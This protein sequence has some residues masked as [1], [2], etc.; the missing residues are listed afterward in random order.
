MR[1]FRRSNWYV[2][3]LRSKP[4]QALLQLRELSNTE[5]ARGTATRF[6]PFGYDTLSFNSVVFGIDSGLRNDGFIG[7]IRNFKLFSEYYDDSTVWR[8]QFVYIIPFKQLVMQVLM[9]DVNDFRN[10]ANKAVGKIVG[11]YK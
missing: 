8:T 3:I 5:I 10:E 7:N 4:N 9:N 1:D 2:L 11:S 6:F